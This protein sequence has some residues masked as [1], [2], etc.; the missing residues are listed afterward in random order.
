[1]RLSLFC[2]NLRMLLYPFCIVNNLFFRAPIDN[3]VCLDTDGFSQNKIK[4]FI[5]LFVRGNDCRRVL[6]CFKTFFVACTTVLYV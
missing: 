3:R 6:K 1:M 5:N 4:V 2:N